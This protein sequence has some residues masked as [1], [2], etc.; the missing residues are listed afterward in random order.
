MESNDKIEA[1]SDTRAATDITRY[2][3]LASGGW[4]AFEVNGAEIAAYEPSSDG[5]EK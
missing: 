4:K 1:S 2:V 3:F 5:T